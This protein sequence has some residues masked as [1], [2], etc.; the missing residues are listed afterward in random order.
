MHA[1]LSPPKKPKT[2]SKIFPIIFPIISR[3]RLEQLGELGTLA[4]NQD[5]IAAFQAVKIANKNRLAD[6]VRRVTGV[7]IL[8]DSMI[9][10]HIKRIHEYK[11]QLL[12]I[13]HVITRYHRILADPQRDW[14]PRTVIFSGKSASAYFMAKLIIKLINDVAQTI[15]A[16][17]RVAGRLK[18]AFIPNYGVS[19]A[20]L[21]IP[22]AD[23]SEQIS[24]AGTEASG[25]GNMKLALNGA[26]TIGT[27]D[28][29]NIEIRDAVGAGNIFVF[30]LHTDEVRKLR[31][32]GYRPRDIYA[33]NPEL[34]Q[35]LD[36]I[37]AGA[38]S[39]GE[40]ARFLPIVQALLDHG[41]HYLLLADYAEYVATQERVDALYA[42]AD[43]WT[44]MAIRNVA[45]M[46]PFS[47][48]RTISEYANNIWGVRSLD[49]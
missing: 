48:D 42:D 19:V 4:E 38:F 35:V 37:A 9:D 33:S 7:A 49:L 30:G 26:L 2:K 34:K 8:Q 45:A 22:A 12:N 41:D 25:T 13:L 15:N 21:I 28:G 17:P 47:S 40:P 29:A 5:F 6:Y 16:D 10:V 27:E 1:Q 24:T 32:S 11:R 23:L 43:A 44:T 20:S 36:Q 31:E 18:V 46:G 39:P 3:T 14:V